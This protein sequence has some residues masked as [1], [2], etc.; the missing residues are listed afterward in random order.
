MPLVAATGDAATGQ[1]L[2]WSREWDANAVLVC[3]VGQSP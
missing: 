2:R 3:A 1:A